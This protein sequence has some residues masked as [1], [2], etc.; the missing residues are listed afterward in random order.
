MDLVTV[1]FPSLRHM[2]TRTD[3]LFSWICVQEQ[4]AS[5]QALIVAGAT[6]MEWPK[7]FIFRAPILGLMSAAAR[8]TSL[9]ILKSLLF[10]TLLLLPVEFMMTINS[11]AQQGS[12]CYSL[13]DHTEFESQLAHLSCIQSF[14][15]G[16]RPCMLISLLIVPVPVTQL[17]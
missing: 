14:F 1:P 7:D 2:C 4:T 3:K 16:Q 11:S 9:L 8:S 13:A 10:F 15:A 6:S 5:N 12:R 17:G